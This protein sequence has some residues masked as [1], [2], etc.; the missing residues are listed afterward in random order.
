ME[1]RRYID[2]DS[3]HIG[4]SQYVAIVQCPFFQ[5]EF[6][7]RRFGR[8]FARAVDPKDIRAFILLEVSHQYLAI[9]PCTNDSKIVF[10]HV[11]S[12]LNDACKNFSI[13]AYTRSSSEIKQA[14]LLLGISITFACGTSLLNWAISLCW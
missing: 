11:S 4:I 10:F 12:M 13:S 1:I 6:L 3:I 9:H 7:R 5:A 14:W 2:Y 8:D